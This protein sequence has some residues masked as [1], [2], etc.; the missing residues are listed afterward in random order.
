MLAKRELFG[1]CASHIPD[2]PLR[3]LRHFFEEQLGESRAARAITSDIMRTRVERAMAE[4]NL[5]DFVGTSLGVGDEGESEDDATSSTATRSTAGA[6]SA[7]R[8]SPSSQK[9]TLQNLR[10][11]IAV[12]TV[13]LS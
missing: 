2:G 12:Y 8:M 10:D 3:V 6:G 1:S 4:I 13:P 11:L 5:L 7:N 9:V